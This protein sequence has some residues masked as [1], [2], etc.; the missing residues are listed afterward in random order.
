[1]REEQVEVAYGVIVDCPPNNQLPNGAAWSP[2][3]NVPVSSDDGS[4]SAT[5]ILLL[6]PGDQSCHLSNGF[7]MLVLKHATLGRDT[8][9]IP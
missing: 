2:V 5:L 1:M 9:Y 3:S 8:Q 6:R 4:V 7:A